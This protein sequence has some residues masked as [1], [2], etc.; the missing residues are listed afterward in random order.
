MSATLLFIHG[1]WLTPAIWQPWQRRYEALGYTTLAPAWPLLDRPIAQL[2]DAPDSELGQLT[3][4]RI[5]DHYATI[6]ATLPEPP[7]LIGHSYGGLIAQMLLDRGLGKAA[8]SIAP[9]PAA[10]IWPGLKAFR[11]A[12]PVF[13]AWRGWSR[14]L[15]MSQESFAR[16][17]ANGL[18]EY[19]QRKVYEE[20]LVP[21]PGRIYYQSVLGINSS[22]NW[23]KSDRAPLLLI[24]A[25]NDRIVEPGMVKQQFERYRAA[26]AHTELHSFPE[27]GQ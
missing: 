20:H 22:I 13:L 11:S 12:L 26:S 3:L 23:R 21:T 27:R 1:A 10:G 25:Q 15:T 14:A 7:I 6:I 19:A 4:G 5:L 24:A 18:D 8:V 17:F 16:H 9:A 2:R